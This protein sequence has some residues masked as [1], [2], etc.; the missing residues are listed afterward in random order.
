[1]KLYTEKY[2][3]VLLR[4]KNIAQIEISNLEEGEKVLEI[5]PGEGFLTQFLLEKYPK[6]TVVESDHRFADILRV[7][8]FDYVEHGQLE[9]IHGDFLEYEGLVQ[10]QIIGNVPYH[11]SSKI[12]QKLS[13]MK[14][15]KAVLMFQS[16]F[17]TTLMAKPST[18]EYT[19][20]T[21]FAYLNF[22][23]EFIKLVSR[24]SFSPIPGVDSAIIS[25]RN[26]DNFPDLDWNLAETK[27]RQMFS[28]KR[29]KL[30]NVIENCPVQ[31]QENRIDQLPPESIINLL[32]NE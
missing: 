29:K 26:H 16:E 8:F 4:D 18:K 5:G 24:N 14:F 10:D 15:N 28:Q 11:I 9:I 13:T 32:R 7:K 19:R 30:K 21:V 27:L 31:F 17:A 6:V 2:G 23:I 12:V 20:M 22:N 25:L 3:Q 1:M